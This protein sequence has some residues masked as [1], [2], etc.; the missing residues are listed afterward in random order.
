M[1]KIKILPSILMLVACVAILGV[2]VFAVAPTKNTISGTITVNT[3]N[4][5]VA[6]EVI[7]GTETIAKYDTVRSGQAIDFGALE[8]FEEGAPQNTLLDADEIRLSIK[9]TNKGTTA[10]GAFYAESTT[11]MGDG[12][13]AD[14]IDDIIY[15]KTYKEG[16]KAIA[17]AYMSSYTPISA[18]DTEEMAI[19]IT[20]AG[21]PTSNQN[22]DLGIT[23]FIEPYE[24]TEEA[25]V[26][27]ANF[28]KMAEGRT[29]MLISEDE[30][31][32][33]EYTAKIFALPKTMTSFMETFYGYTNCDD[34]VFN[35]PNNASFRTS[36][37]TD[38][39]NCNFVAFIPKNAT[40]NA[41]TSGGDNI[42]N[43]FKGAFVSFDNENLSND[44]Q[45]AVY[46]KNKTTLY[47]CCTSVHNG[48]QF[49][50]PQTLTSISN[51]VAMGGE[52]DFSA[53][54]NLKE[55][56]LDC[57]DSGYVAT[58]DV[59]LPSGL[60]TLSRSDGGSSEYFDGDI[61]TFTGITPPSTINELFIGNHSTEIRIPKGTIEVYTTALNVNNAESLTNGDIVIEE[62]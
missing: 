6:L 46:N 38:Y 61:I 7:K 40:S 28:V 9:V 34:A 13:L 49:I 60:E 35:I 18:G 21:F 58:C 62:Y 5:P 52:F 51:N 8:F 26:L 43:W 15:Q 4:T 41:I 45:Y 44:N 12:E 27:T 39:D 36:Y 42:S 17:Q 30:Y 56:N 19:S 50:A 55:I 29:D 3:A 53:C 37:P 48:R 59:V 31:G 14:G 57:L 22:F 2:G 23:L 16:T 1:K 11:V 47:L 54:S 33:L 24:A 25:N 20:L 32:Y 10:V